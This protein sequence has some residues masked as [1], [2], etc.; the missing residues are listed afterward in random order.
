MIYYIIDNEVQDSL[1]INNMEV[2]FSN[3]IDY[4]DTTGTSLTLE[5]PEISTEIMNIVQTPKTQKK[6]K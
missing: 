4:N 2:I 5:D 3:G 1:Q 6:S